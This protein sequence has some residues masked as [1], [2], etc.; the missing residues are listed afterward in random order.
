MV[1]KLFKFKNSQ[2]FSLMII[3][4]SAEQLKVI[5][6]APNVRDKRLLSK[7]LKLEIKF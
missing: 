3:K 2:L 7:I 5:Y 1:G 4:C 6:L